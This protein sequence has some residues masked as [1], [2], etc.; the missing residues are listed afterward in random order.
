MNDQLT[1]KDNIQNNEFILDN[2]DNDYKTLYKV[3]IEG[4]RATN[5]KG[6]NG[7]FLSK[8]A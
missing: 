8:F 3:Y 1:P 7:C 5:E 4:T 6:N 2:E